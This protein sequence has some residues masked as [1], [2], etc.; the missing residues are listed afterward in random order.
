MR[1]TEAIHH[2]R[3]WFRER[4]IGTDHLTIIINISNKDEAARLDYELK[5]DLHSLHVL[6][7]E[8]QS[9][10]DIRRM[11]IEGVSVHIESPLHT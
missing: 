10:V 1:F 4:D 7:L 2:V 8:D 6:Q 5:R 3:R 11:S 9:L